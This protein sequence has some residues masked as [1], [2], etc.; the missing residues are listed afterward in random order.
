MSFTVEGL[1]NSIVETILMVLVSTL[2]AYIIGLPLGILLSI[3]SK[4]GLK[5]NKYVNTILGIIVNILRSI[6]CLLAIVILIPLSN[7]ILG[8][9][10]WQGHWYSMIIPLVFVSFG[11]I[12]RMVETS[13]NEVENGKIEAAKSLGATTFQII[14]KVMLS[15]ARSSLLS[16]FAAGGGLIYYAFNLG[17]Y[18]TNE[19][20]MWLCVIAIVIIVQIIQE[21]TLLISRKIDRKRR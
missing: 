4:K 7:I 5:P 16:G 20:A 11:F 2:I 12:A 17:F 8:K 10:N 14:Y 19:T 21:V 15:E 13:L 1:M 18:G 9:G 3:T 6:P